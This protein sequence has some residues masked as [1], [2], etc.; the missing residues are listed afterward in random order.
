[1]E[2]IKLD[3]IISKWF[4]IKYQTYSKLEHNGTIYLYYDGEEYA[5]IR[6]D[7]KYERL[8]Y[9][10]KLYLEISLI[11]SLQQYEFEDFMIT[12]VENTFKLNELVG[13]YYFSEFSDKLKI[14]K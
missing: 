10:R 11:I 13:A 9:N 6:I 14:P 2:E 12:W 1:M 3:K 8:F 5:D 4:D 7:A